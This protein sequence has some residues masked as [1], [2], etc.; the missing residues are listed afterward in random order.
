MTIENLPDYPE[1][2]QVNQALWRTGRTRGAAVLVGA[3]FSRNA[4]RIHEG[5]PMPPVWKA[6]TKAL[7]TRLGSPANDHKEPLRIAKEFIAFLGRTA[8]D[9]LIMEMIPDDQWLPGRLHKKLVAL[10]WAGRTHP[11]AAGAAGVPSAPADG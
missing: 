10:N 2:E 3:G 8:L 7:Q 4:E 9:G 1:I 11:T 6:L 5:T